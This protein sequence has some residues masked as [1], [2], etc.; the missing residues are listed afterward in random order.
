MLL[1]AG[2]SAIIGTSYRPVSMANG[3]MGENFCYPLA[4]TRQSRRL[5]VV[6]QLI[7]K[8][9]SFSI[10]SMWTLASVTVSR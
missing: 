6:A 9:H 5:P 1:A 4:L 3:L 8:N 7:V 10:S 2:G